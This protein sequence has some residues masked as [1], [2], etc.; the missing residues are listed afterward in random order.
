MF[1]GPFGKSNIK[2]MLNRTLALLILTSLM[3]CKQATKAPQKELKKEP[4]NI[5]SLPADWVQLTKTDSGFIIFE[6]CDMGN[7]LLTI[8]NKQNKPGILIHGTQEDY[9]FDILETYLSIN[10]TV[11]I[12]ARW[13][14][15][16]ELQDFKFLWAD[17]AKQWGRWITNYHGEHISDEVFVTARNQN[18]IPKVDQPC[19]ECWDEE[20]C[21]YLE[22]LKHIEA[23]PVDTI[24]RIFEEYVKTTEA[25]DS[26]INKDFMTRAL[27]NLQNVSDTAA[28]D[29]LVNV[30]MYYDPTDFPTR[31]LVD[32]V[33]KQNKTGSIKAVKKRME[34]KR[35]GE[36]E[37]TAPYSALKDLLSELE[38]DN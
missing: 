12:K 13:T 28:L 23:H 32:T 25:T 33:L 37:N 29:L 19:R 24:K 17:K 15:S 3:A 38:K 31:P 35:T 2:A 34:I 11:I 14:G 5:A 6:S 27:Y 21:N 1:D 9:E 20:E 36:S 30:W 16:K 10:D 8:T 7:A 4:F 26:P 22:Q 18:N